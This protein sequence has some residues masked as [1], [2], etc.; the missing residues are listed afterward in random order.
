MKRRLELRGVVQDIAIYDDFAHHPTAISATIEALRGK[1]K[2]KRILAVLEC[3]SYTM[4]TGVHEHALP[5]SLQGA[6]AA[7][8]LQPKQADWDL[9]GSMRHTSIPVHIFDQVDEIVQALVTEAKPGDQIL[10]MSNTGFS[11]IHQKL[12]AALQ[13]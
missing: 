2:Q 13:N 8:I 6:D 4:R 1:E 3:G 11:G 12:L 9:T 10:V 5:T 7:Y